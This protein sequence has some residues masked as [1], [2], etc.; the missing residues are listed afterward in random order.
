MC[1]CKDLSDDTDVNGYNTELIEYSH[2]CG[3]EL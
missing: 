3:G 2:L 1:T